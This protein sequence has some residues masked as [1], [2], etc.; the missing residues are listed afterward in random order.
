MIQEASVPQ[1]ANE[2]GWIWLWRNGL[3]SKLTV[4][5]Y[6]YYLGVNST[7]IQNREMQAYYSQLETEWLRSEP[8]LAGVLAFCYLANNYG[9]TGDWFIDNIK[10][11]NPAPTLEW[12]TSAFAPYG[13]FINLTDE[14]YFKN[15]DPHKPGEKFNLKLVKINDFSR[16]VAGKVTLKILDS[17]GKTVEKKV[18]PII[19]S[20]FD[21]SSFSAEISLPGKPG[22][23]L[24]LAEFM[25]DGSSHPVISRRFINVGVLPEYKYFEMQPVKLN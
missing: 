9:Y 22:G 12:F 4:D 24:L 13:I 11:L 8:S 21:R 25:A 5:V 6:N 19:L 3:P 2:Y 20:P 7:P 17:S 23:Y 1:L 16:N 14:R 15:A 18:L 10:D